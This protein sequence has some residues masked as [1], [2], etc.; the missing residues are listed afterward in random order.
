MEHRARMNK[1]RLDETDIKLISK[2]LD[3]LKTPIEV[4]YYML[5]HANLDSFVIVLLS[6]KNVDIN[7]VI[8]KNKRETDIDFC[9]DKVSKLHAVLC[10]ETKIDEGYVFGERITKQIAQNGGEN[11]YC[12]EL[13]VKTTRYP[14]KELIFRVYDAYQQAQDEDMDG[15]VVVKTIH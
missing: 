6:A 3:T 14:A 5:E 10:Q 4:I 13:E 1:L 7:E 15:E 12:T 8:M 9:I 11:V 2:L